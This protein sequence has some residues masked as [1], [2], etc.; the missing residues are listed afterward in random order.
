MLVSL[1]QSLQTY[2]H[3][4][5]LSI[6]TG[7]AE[8]VSVA[9]PL[10]GGG[11]SLLQ[12]QHGYSLD[13]LVSARV[14]LASGKVMEA[15]RTK[16]ADLFWALQGAGHNFG[17]VTAL[18]VKTYDIPSNWTVYSL[19]FTTDKIEALFSLINEFEEPT[20]ERPTKL[21]LTGVFA[22][23]PA[24]D[25]VNVSRARQHVCQILTLH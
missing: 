13:G 10:L 14:V 3:S 25:P 1:T 18:Q 8:C 2:S 24:V 4:L 15:S 9:G 19:V 23:I 21:A 11:H 7:L 17:I 20:I 16:N 12:G 22:R 5:H 6:V